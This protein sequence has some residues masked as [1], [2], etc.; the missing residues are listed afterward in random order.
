MVYSELPYLIQQVLSVGAKFGYI[1]KRIYI[2][3]VGRY[4]SVYKYRVWNELEKLKLISAWNGQDFSKN[5]YYLN[6]KGRELML[7]AGVVAVAKVHPIYF[8][9]DNAV[10]KF[11]LE[12]ANALHISAD[13]QT[14][15]SMRLY[16]NFKL[17]QIFGGQLNKFP[18]LLI[19]LN[20]ADQKV[21]IALEVEKSAKSQSRYDAFVVGYSKAKDID[22]VL[23]AHSHKFTREA[24]LVSMRRLAYPRAKRPIAFCSF[25]DF[26]NNPTNFILEIEGHRIKFSEYVRNIQQIVENQTN[27]KSVKIELTSELTKF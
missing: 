8:E 1:N 12:N 9:H 2:D 5:Y 25:S 6:K 16:D 21:T 23:V 17:H 10:M 24:L 3:H 20:V 4:S 18:D 13:Y 14:E 19:S 11:A 27:Q 26:V 7:R 15:S 22:M